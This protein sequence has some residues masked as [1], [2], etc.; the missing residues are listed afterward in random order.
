MIYAKNKRF[1]NKNDVRYKKRLVAKDYTQT[2]GLD[3][4]EVF[5]PIV[6]HSSIRIL[7]ALVAQLDLE[8]V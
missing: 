6:K 7:L 8:I 5:S 4:N 1:P 3:Y 2:K